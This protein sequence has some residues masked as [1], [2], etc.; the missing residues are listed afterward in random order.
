MVREKKDD[1][2][3][4]GFKQ[5][6]DNNKVVIPKTMFDGV[7]EKQALEVTVQDVKRDARLS[8]RNGMK[9]IGLFHW[10]LQM[11]R[12]NTMSHLIRTPLKML[13]DNGLYFTGADFI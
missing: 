13:K 12:N 3:W 9:L 11:M 5:I 2:I 4:S 1:G 6:D 10:W 7:T 8:Y